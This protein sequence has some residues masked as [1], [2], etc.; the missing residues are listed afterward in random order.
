MTNE[1]ISSKMK[2][3]AEQFDIKKGNLVIAIVPDRDTKDDKDCWGLECGK[4]IEC[5]S[6][7]EQLQRDNTNKIFEQITKEL[8]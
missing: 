2:E 3:P 8:D 1:E 6:L 4:V 5:K 7:I